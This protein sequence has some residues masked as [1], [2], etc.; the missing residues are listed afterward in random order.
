MIQI[1]L[2]FN[3]TTYP[4]NEVKIIYRPFN[5]FR[6]SIGDLQTKATAKD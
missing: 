3:I 1:L 4:Y 5:S 6:S 2:Y